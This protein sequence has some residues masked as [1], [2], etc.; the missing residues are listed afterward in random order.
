MSTAAPYDQDYNL[1]EEDNKAGPS[2]N[3]KRGSRACDRCRKIKSKCEHTDG[4]VCK[5][6][7]QAGTPCTYHGPSFKRGPPKGYIQSIEKRWHQVECVLG[8][9]MTSPRAQSVIA[10]LCTDPFARE[11]L[12]RVDSGPYA[13]HCDPLGPTGRLRQPQGATNENVYSAVMNVPERTPYRDDR[14]SNRQSRLSRE[15]VS[16]EADSSAMATPTREWQEQLVRRLLGQEASYPTPLMSLSPEASGHI[17]PASQ[18][19][20]YIGVPGD[21]GR[22]RRRLDGPSQPPHKQEWNGLYAMSDD[23]HSNPGDVDDTVDAFGAL[24]VDENKEIRYHG[25]SSGLPLLAHSDRTDDSEQKRD[26]IWQFN[27]PFLSGENADVAQLENDS[28][29]T[30]PPVEIQD[31]LIDLYFTYVH[32]VFPL[33]HKSTFLQEYRQSKVHGFITLDGTHKPSAATEHRPMQKVTKLLLLSMFAIASR[34]SD[35]EEPRPASG[36]GVWKAGFS[37]A[38]LARWILNNTFSYSRPS[39]C[40]ALLLLGICDLGLGAT[41]QGWIYTGLALR[42]AIDLGMNRN[43]DNWTNED[44]ELF[45]PVEK[46]MRKQIWWSCCITDKLSA[47]WLGRPI[48]FRESDYSTLRPDILDADEYELWQPSPSDA[49][50]LD[51]TPTPCRTMSSFREACLLSVIMTEIMEKIY[52]V[53]VYTATPR[54]TLLEQLEAKLHKWLFDLPDHL[55]YSTTGQRSTPLPH[56]LVLHMEYCA[57]VLLLHRAFL[58]ATENV[59][60]LGG[61][62]NMTDPVPLKSFDICQS[63]ATHISSLASVYGEKYGL[64]RAPPFLSIYLQSAGIMHVIT[65]TRRPQNAQATKGLIQCISAL[66]LMEVT[67]PSA[68]RVR[69]LL[70]GAKVDLDQTSSQPGATPARQKRSAEAAWGAE[71]SHEVL[72]RQAYAQH[73]YQAPQYQP[74]ANNAA[75]PQQGPSGSRILPDTLGT[76]LSGME[77]STSFYPGYQWWPRTTEAYVNLGV[78]I[79]DQQLG[80]GAFGISP[81]Q[82]PSASQSHVPQADFTFDEGN[83]TQDF[84]QGVHYPLLDF[85]HFYPQN[86]NPGQ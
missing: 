29:V 34:F 27:V 67:W 65:L 25:Q 60:A 24:S 8:T 79:Y 46:Q 12:A 48:T 3:T 15:I 38:A 47:I 5:N 20:P 23:S 54:R 61:S 66:K 37:Y 51:F 18:S 43:A 55:R 63:A 73:H 28:R 44:R 9:I 57:A 1:S 40:Q 83:I 81:L 71:H 35:R 41:Q 82:T 17:T 7:Q 45:S 36:T 69:T 64:D 31:H 59:A 33:L 80:I 10:D 16:I 4:D 84:A 86:P 53:Q 11:I 6:C 19:S 30:L 13:S 22:S 42:M 49:L 32:P 70:E 21:H 14:R 74:E 68:I 26:G 58:P 77:A 56:V 50:G 52:P 76:N 75:T 78:Q 2:A 72:Q 85:T 62:P 39:T